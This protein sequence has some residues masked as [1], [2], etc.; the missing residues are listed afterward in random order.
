MCNS[1]PTGTEQ[2]G[3]EDPMLTQQ[4]AYKAIEKASSLKSPIQKE[5]RAIEEQTQYLEMAVTELQDAVYQLRNRLEPITRPQPE[6][7]APSQTEVG[8]YSGSSAHYFALAD[9]TSRV[10][11]LRNRVYDLTSL[12]EL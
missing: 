4:R 7:E 2:A 10:N 3:M 11:S 12:I 1:C 5:K 8:A 6:S 9:Q